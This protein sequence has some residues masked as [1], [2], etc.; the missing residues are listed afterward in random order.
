[1]IALLML[2]SIVFTHLNDALRAACRPDPVRIAWWL[3]AA[4]VRAEPNHGHNPAS[5]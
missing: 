5:S 4:L 3:Q 1:M 2:P